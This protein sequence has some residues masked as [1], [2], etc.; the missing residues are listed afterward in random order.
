[1]CTRCIGAPCPLRCMLRCPSRCRWLQGGPG[2]S[3]TGYGNFDEMGPLD[4]NLNPRNTTWVKLANVLYLD[5]PVGTGFSYADS[6]D[7]F[8]TD[9]AQIADDMVRFLQQWLKL[10]PNFKT[11]PFYVFCES[12]GGKMTTGLA[13][14]LL[15]AIDNASIQLDFR[16]VAL[17]DS[18]IDGVDFTLAWAPYLQQLSLL[19]P[20]EAKAIYATALETQAAAQAGEWEKATQLWGTVED[21]I[22]AQAGGVSFYNF[23]Q[24]APAPSAASV[25]LYRQHTQWRAPHLASLAARHLDVF[26]ADPL[27]TLMNGPIRKKLGIIPSNVTWSGQAGQV[28]QSLSGDFM[29][30]V[31]AEV[32]ALIAGGRINVT[33]YEGQLDV[34]CLTAGA[35]MWMS[36]LQWPGM[37]HFHEAPKTALGA[38]PGAEIGAFYKSYAN[39]HMWY[40]MKAGHMVPHDNGQMAYIMVQHLLGQA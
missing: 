40:I 36:K 34:I 15:T 29:K 10:Y 21:E 33:V 2:A 8:T 18:W 6:P 13:T 35:E 12:Y 11:Q 38:Y 7:V 19:T 14:A 28:F 9:N 30:P 1:M 37:P 39:L 32:D 26:A 4:T 24:M 5:Q 20:P 23:L 27:Y 16:G 31:W 3:S 25:P 17:G 22:E